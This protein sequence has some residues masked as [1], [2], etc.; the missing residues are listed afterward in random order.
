M[1]SHFLPS[2]VS[3]L[4]AGA[5]LPH[6]FQII[7]DQQRH[8]VF[9]L[10]DRVSQNVIRFLIDPVRENGQHQ[11]SFGNEL[12]PGFSFKKEPQELIFS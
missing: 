1:N 7:L 4:Y 11:L 10:Q 8:S 6:I 12:L 2:S 9:D 5:D 3:V